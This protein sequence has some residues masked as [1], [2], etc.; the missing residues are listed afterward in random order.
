MALAALLFF[1]SSGSA[2]AAEKVGSEFAPIADLLEQ[3]V[4]C[5]GDKGASKKPEFPILAGQHFYYL[6]VQLKDFN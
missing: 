2:N 3:C 1:A 5:H 4:A 6:Y